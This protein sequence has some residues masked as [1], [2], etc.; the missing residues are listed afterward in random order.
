MTSFPDEVLEYVLKFITT[1]KDRN[2]VSLVC[3]AWYSVEGW[4]RQSVFIGNCYA[5]SP[6]ILINRFPRIKTMTLKGRPRFADFNLF[7]QDWGA[8]LHPWVVTMAARYPWLEEL[9]LKRMTVSDECL[10]MLAHAFPNFRVLVLTSCDG[11]STDGLA[12]IAGHCRHLTVL[13]LQESD[14]ENRG[15]HWL[16]CFPETCTSLVCLNFACLN[17]VV[18]FDALEKLVERCTSLKSLKLNKGVSLEQLQRLL[19]RAPQLCDLGTGSYSQ[20]LK[21]TQYAELQT[22]ITNCKDLRSLSGFWDVAPVFVP[23][24]YPIGRN[25]TTLNLSYA[26]I[27]GN[28]LMKLVSHC[29]NLKRLWVQDF[30]EDKGLQ[31]VGMNCKELQELRVFP[32]D[33]LGHGYVTEI[34]LVAISEG[35]PNLSSVLYFCRQ[36]T[37]A[38]IIAV[39]KNCPNLT[40]F[41][42]CIITPQRPD[43]ETG[44]PMDEAFGAIVKHCKD[45]RRLALS[46]LLTDKAFEYIGLYG[47]RLQ[48]LSVAFA[49]DSDLAMQYVL[50]GCPNLRKLE[51][52]DSPFGD[53]ALLSGLHRYESMRFLW[54]SACNITLIGCGW[55]ANQLPRLN[56]EVIKENENSRDLTIEKLYAYRS[57]AGPRSDAPHCVVTL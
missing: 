25:L 56:V 14:I 39:A 47:K 4:N 46:G 27:R 33:P 55:L 21:W 50:N 24:L 17:S 32:V 51:I 6:E 9:R 42:L 35:C 26:T 38:A 54:M 36:C 29:P 30:V 1:H 48:T 45:L 28:V 53:A 10:V 5:V 49:G 31:A 37:N 22:A 8:Y 34:G 13:D 57:V 23:S 11:F 19:V 44:E 41:R 16:S 52:R 12:A 18:D 2:A 3:K 43:H 15:G 7:P 20:Q 40:R